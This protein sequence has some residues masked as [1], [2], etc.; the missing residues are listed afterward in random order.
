MINLKNILVCTDFSPAAEVALEYG[1]NMAR[2]FGASMRVLHVVEK[3]ATR[4][5]VD[6]GYIALP[7]LQKELEDGARR[8]LAAIVTDDDRRT[9]HAESALVTSSSP[10]RA[11]VE[12]ANAEAIDLIVV[13][14]H[15]R[16][17]VSRVLLG[18]IAERVVRTAPCPVLTVHDPERALIEPDALAVVATA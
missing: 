3:M 11:I 15:G 17:G 18:S 2:T 4:Y 8:R 6:V 5:Y 1:R 14:T 12:F 10:A 7:D 9:L 13:G 16:S